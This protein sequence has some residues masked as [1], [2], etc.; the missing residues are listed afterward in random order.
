[1]STLMRLNW[2]LIRVL[3]VLGSAGDVEG[4]E[5][6]LV[7]QRGRPADRTQDQEIAR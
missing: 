4:D 3:H 2:Q 7:P 1:M 6:M 5:G